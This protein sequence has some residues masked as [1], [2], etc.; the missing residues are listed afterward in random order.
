MSYPSRIL[1]TFN[2]STPKFKYTALGGIAMVRPSNKL[3]YFTGA[4]AYASYT[5]NIGNNRLTS[6]THPVTWYNVK[7][8]RPAVTVSMLSDTG[9]DY[10]TLN[11]KF[12]PQLGINIREGQKVTVAGTGGVVEN[13]YYI[14]PIPFQIGNLKPV[15]GL[16][17]IGSGGG[18]DVLGRTQALN[19]FELSYNKRQLKYTELNQAQSNHG[20]ARWRGR[21]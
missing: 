8:N 12:A 18:T 1:N 6:P 9:A 21:I 7:T 16:V 14:H 11:D 20:Q 13:A 5:F 15:L 10:S 19:N 2:L 3:S 4:E 17:A